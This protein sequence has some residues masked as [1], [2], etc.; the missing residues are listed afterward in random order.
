MPTLLSHETSKVHSA[1][2][3]EVLAATVARLYVAH[4]NPREWTYSGAGA[5]V[6]VADG[7]GGFQFNLVDLTSGRSVW[8]LDLR[9]DIKYYTD[10]PFFHSFL[11]QNSMAGF[12]FADEFEASEFHTAYI[13]REN[14]TPRSSVSSRPSVTTRPSTA[15]PP[16][17]IQAGPP[18]ATP[19][20]PSVAS[21][22]P[23]PATSIP[24]SAS[25]SQVKDAGKKHEKE[26][27]GGLFSM[28]KKKGK[29]TKGK[30]DKSMI[31]APDASTFQHV[32]HVGYNAKSGFSAQNIPMEWKVI[33]AKA[34]ITE[35]QLQNDKATQR[36]VKRFMRDHA[37]ARPPST[38]SDT[39]ASLPPSRPSV[40]APPPPPVAG[41]VRRAP[42]PPPPSRR[43]PA[44]PPPVRP[45]S[46][47][48]AAPPPAHT[49]RP[50]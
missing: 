32:S 8:D 4:P 39:G 23:S 35:D 19:S 22:A 17:P 21:P 9:R 47:A 48:P 12:S 27:S 34:G 2:Q 31:S 37:G 36:V 42:P 41:G 28:G 29:K 43:G 20:R 40:A 16:L 6:L 5:A 11:G 13:R 10:R 30:I 26:S 15:G 1:V 49:P 25:T 38:A 46:T 33:F 50:W 24:K 3:G 45:G 44:P 7:N 18:P 14:S